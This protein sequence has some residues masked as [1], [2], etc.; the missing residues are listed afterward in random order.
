M[1]QEG[2]RKEIS[3]LAGSKTTMKL[4]TSKKG[5]VLGLDILVLDFGAGEGSEEHYGERRNMSLA[6]MKVISR[7]STETMSD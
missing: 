2:N 5:R 4:H 1:R 7:M 3:S 6:I